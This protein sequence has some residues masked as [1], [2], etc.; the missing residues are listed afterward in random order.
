MATN[1]VGQERARTLWQADFRGPARSA[2]RLVTYDGGMSDAVLQR[3]AEERDRL[4]VHIEE[5]IRTRDALEGLMA[6]NRAH[7][8]SLRTA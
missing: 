2:E 4:S 1:W 7:R 6:T 3:M 8:E 5:L